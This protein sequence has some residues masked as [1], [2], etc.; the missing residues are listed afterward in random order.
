MNRQPEN[1]TGAIKPALKLLAP[2][3]LACLAI[4]GCARED[5]DLATAETADG[6]DAA[7]EAPVI[8]EPATEDATRPLAD[9]TFADPCTGLTG[10][11]LD[12]CLANQPDAA[13]TGDAGALDDEGLMDDEGVIEDE[14]SI[15][16]TEMLDE[17]PLEE[18]MD[19]EAVED[20]NEVPP[21]A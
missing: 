3:L 2:A 1:T 12:D 5:A 10:T 13:T 18:P 8:T 21:P 19:E 20:P 7:A 11:A 16:D 14:Q 4:A 15:G 17:E 6:L 9:Q